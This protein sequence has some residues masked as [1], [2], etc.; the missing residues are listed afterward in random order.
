MANNVDP[1]SKLPR[2]YDVPAGYFDSLTIPKPFD[3]EVSLH[4]ILLFLVLC[5]DS[6]ASGSQNFSPTR[7][8]ECDD[9]MVT[10]DAFA[11]YRLE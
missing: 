9:V 10:A 11:E 4:I 2:S 1:V 8:P 6:R 5:I 3:D 7:V